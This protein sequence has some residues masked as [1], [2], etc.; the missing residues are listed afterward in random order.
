MGLSGIACCDCMVMF[1]W[2]VEGC[3]LGSGDNADVGLII[4]GCGGDRTLDDDEA[5]VSGLSTI[6]VGLGGG[7]LVGD[8]C[9][10]TLLEAAKSVPAG[11]VI[12]PCPSGFDCC[13]ALA[14][15]R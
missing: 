10:G 1:G 9:A 14:C 15:S 4:C 12:V 3:A 5:W 6:M 11:E 8:S 2:M 13:C 7:C